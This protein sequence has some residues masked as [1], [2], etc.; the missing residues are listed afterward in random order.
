MR[1]DEK[2]TS[3]IELEKIT[4]HARNSGLIQFDLN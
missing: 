3:F 1:A 2:L 4:R